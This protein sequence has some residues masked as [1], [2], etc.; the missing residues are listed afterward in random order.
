VTPED[1]FEK[2]RPAKGYLT[3]CE[4]QVGGGWCARTEHGYHWGDTVGEAIQAAWD[5]ARGAKPKRF[6]EAPPAA[7]LP[8]RRVPY[9]YR[10]C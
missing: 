9:D 10:Q 4:E 3:I 6:R 1:Y 7:G 8:F 5:R 2:T